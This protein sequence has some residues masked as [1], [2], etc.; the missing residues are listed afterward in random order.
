MA[1]EISARSSGGG[2]LQDVL[3]MRK[4]SRLARAQASV[5]LS[6][7]ENVPLEIVG[8]HDPCVVPRAVPCVEAAVACALW[9]FMAARPCP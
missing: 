4:P 9:D 7:G 6:R 8:R 3:R 2:S 1:A 5:S